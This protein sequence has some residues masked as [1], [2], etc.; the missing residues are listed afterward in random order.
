MKIAITGASG[1]LGQKLIARLLADGDQVRA[2]G[3]SRRPE[4]PETVTFFAWD[5]LAGEPPPGSMD[6]VDAV[7]NLAGEPV[8]Q[9]WSAAVKHKIR[10]SRVAG[11][12][13]LVDA[14]SK[15]S[16]PPSVLVSGS[17]SGYYGNRG[18]ELLTEVSPPGQGLLPEVCVEWE[19]QA[20]L[21][22][23]HGIR[24]VLV[25]TGIVLGPE[26][27]ALKQMLPAFRLGAGATLGSG[28]QWMSWIHVDDWIE[29]FVFAL[30]VQLRGPANG[31]S[32][33]PVRNAEF[34]GALAA[35]MHRPAF[36]TAP[37]FALK[38]LFGEMSAILLDSQRLLPNA[39]E[40]AGFHF[41]HPTLEGALADLL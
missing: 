10:E 40:T 34:T 18:E 38:L 3:R 2:L 15:L 39:A 20:K 7:V 35:A 5:A 4:L 22:E 6:G 37:A 19:R 25:R 14:M 23:T 12:R 30:R 17:A 24:T 29:L 1:F 11:T 13:H 32:P 41:R 31:V 33:N 26:G 16:R 8:A 21:S 27:G 9:R 28:K 36:V